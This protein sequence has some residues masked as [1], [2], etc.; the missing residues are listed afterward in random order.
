MG[1]TVRLAGASF[2]RRS[3][4]QVLALAVVCAMAATA[5]VAGLAAQTSAADLA[6]RAYET[7]GRPDLVLYGSEAALARA[8]GDP[9]VA[10]GGQALPVAADLETVVDGRPVELE[11]IGV[12]ATDLPAVGA[13][14]L[15]DG[16][17]ADGPDEIVAERSLVS[18]DVVE[19]G[20]LLRVDTADGP[21]DL[22]VVGA[23]VDISDCFWPTCDPLRT[24]APPQTVADLAGPDGVSHL[25]AYRLVDAEAAAAVG[26]RLLA[27]PAV[28]IDGA[29]NWPDTRSD[30]LIVGTV[31]ST[32]VGG[33]G[34]ILLLAAAFVVAGA[35]AARMVARRRSLGLL[36]AVGFR[37]VQLYLAVWIE[38]LVVGT[39][40][41]TVGWLVG[42]A[43]APA[44]QAGLGDVLPGEPT[45]LDL[46]SLVVAA[47]LV[48]SLLT[49]SVL[50]PAVRA[51][52]RPPTEALQ[53][54]PPS[55]SGGRALAGLARRLGAGPSTQAGVRRTFAR[56]GRAVLAGG[57]LAVAAAGTVIAVGFLTTLSDVSAD[58][59]V[60]GNP[61]DVAVAPRTASAGEIEA[62]LTDTDGV[63][64][65]FTEDETAGTV[66]GV[67]YTVRLMG[68]D[69]VAA[70]YVVQEGRALRSPDE[71]IVGYGVLE[72]TGLD[73]GDP[74]VVTVDE[75]TVELEI[76][77]W[78]SDTADGGKMIQV[79][80][81]AFPATDP[82]PTWRVVV[83]DGASADAVATDLQARFGVTASVEA[84]EVDDIAGAYAAMVAMAGLLLLV[85]FVNLVATTVSSTRE[86]A[87]ALGVLRTI[88]CSTGQLVGQSAVGA[89]MLGFLAAAVAVPVGWWVSLEL[90]DALT[91]GI[92]IGPGFASSPPLGLALGVV[93]AVVGLAAAAGAL[94]TVGLAR[95]SAAALVRYE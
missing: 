74:L 33:F 44:F 37:P 28:G 56:P 92:G 1:A 83:A 20:G 8:A 35:T 91:A 18:E 4:S 22:R 76:V 17:W 60:T 81:E 95:R 39:I 94:A 6:D 68:G 85:A 78:Y 63:A 53:D 55:A 82:D 90:G 69:P 54:V 65:W 10:A 71:A 30:I 73:I 19:V 80:E 36:R 52:R 31:F 7:A 34:T 45:R 12:E 61:W 14:Q 79:R 87:R 43:L 11:M 16:R 25:A 72:E 40:G 3:R 59:A 26:G 49:V 86:R 27:D 62:A 58:P 84:L 51:V 41:V 2:R 77:G 21:R 32:L 47:V 64:A 89:G 29:N 67:G 57:A 42:T 50:V 5:V 9:A 66:D 23:A 15:V 13:P 46:R 70:G 75:E 38:H 93:V 48:L 24:F 88:G